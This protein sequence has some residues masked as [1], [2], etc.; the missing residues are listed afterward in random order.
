V[1]TTIG[2]WR[3]IS[4]FLRNYDAWGYRDHIWS[5]LPLHCLACS[6]HVF[7]E[8]IHTHLSFCIILKVWYNLFFLSLCNSWKG[9]NMSV[10]FARCLSNSNLYR[11]EG[12][13]I[14]C[15]RQVECHSLLLTL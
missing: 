8:Y 1:P 11:N 12:G 2:W 7:A 10:P 4:D 6:R 14:C 5:S 3:E 15:L 9:V 13:H